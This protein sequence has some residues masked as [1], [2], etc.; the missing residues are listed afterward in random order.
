MIRGQASGLMVRD[1][2][3]LLKFVVWLEVQILSS[4][5]DQG[6]QKSKAA[7]SKCAH[8]PEKHHLESPLESRLL[9]LTLGMLSNFGIQGHQSPRITTENELEFRIKD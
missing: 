6:V 7:F 2:D 5:K 8:L 1:V 4:T 3:M 9:G